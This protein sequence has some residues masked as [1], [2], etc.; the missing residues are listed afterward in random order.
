MTIIKIK[1]LAGYSTTAG[2][3]RRH[4]TVWQIGFE[5]KLLLRAPRGRAAAG[6]GVS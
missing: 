2:T 4:A 3:G 5:I 6:V 1:K